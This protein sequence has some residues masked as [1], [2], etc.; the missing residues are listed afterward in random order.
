M[1]ERS[2]VTVL[3][4]FVLLG[5]VLAALIASALVALAGAW[6]FDKLTRERKPP[7]T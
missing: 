4:A 5:L 7:V 2:T 1:Y 3:D 6:L